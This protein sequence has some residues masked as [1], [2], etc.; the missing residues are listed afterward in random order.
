MNI[1]CNIVNLCPLLALALSLHW[2]HSWAFKFRDANVILRTCSNDGHG[3]TT[4]EQVTNYEPYV[5]LISGGI[6]Q[7]ILDK[8]DDIVTKSNVSTSCKESLQFVNKSL[9]EGDEASFRLIDASAKMPH[10]SIEGTVTNLGD[11]DECINIQEPQ[12]IGKYCMVDVF[13][14]R[15]AIDRP[16][17]FQF[18][19]YHFFNQTARF[20]GLCFPDTC[21]TSDVR[22]IVSRVLSPLTVRV[23][24]DITC[25]TLESTSYLSKLLSMT[26]GQIIS[27]LALMAVGAFV[28]LGTINDFLAIVPHDSSYL[29]SFLFSFSLRG[30]FQELVAPYSDVNRIPFVDWFKFWIIMTGVTAHI[31]TCLETPLGFFILEKHSVFQIVFR[32]VFTQFTFNDGGLGWI[33]FLSAFSCYSTLASAIKSKTFRFPMAVF[34]RW[35]KF[36][37]VIAAITALD[38]TWPLL[39]SGPFYTRVG[40]YISNKCSSNWWANVAFVSIFLPALD[41]CAPHTY[42]ASIDFLL[43][44]AGIFTIHLLIHYTKLGYSICLSAV[45]AGYWLMIHFGSLYSVPPSVMTPNIHP[46]KVI[47]FLDIIQMSPFGFMTNYFLGLLIAHLTSTGLLIFKLK[48]ALDHAIWVSAVFISL[49]IAEMLPAIYN[50]FNL[51]PESFIPYYLVVNRAAFTLSIT[52]LVIYSASVVKGPSK[53]DNKSKSNG[54]SKEPSKLDVNNNEQVNE[55]TK[56]LK[57]PKLFSI[58]THGFMRLK[59]L[60]RGIGSFFFSRLG[61]IITRLSFAIFLSNYFYIRLD[62]F[63]SRYTFENTV[64]ALVS[65]AQMTI[66]VLQNLTNEPLCLLFTSIFFSTSTG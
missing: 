66:W 15:P 41:I 6:S 23:T 61:A 55:G 34:D 12:L 22:T 57:K 32:S 2:S 19:K 5:R 65:I 17:L 60:S 36:A 28:F 35:I 37:P 30:N 9:H 46:Q 27:V 52:I 43:F 16:G 13:V 45:A 25:D 14:E 42:Y 7:L 53:S 26:K 11:Y 38:F 3:C 29:S 20:F 18:G 47:N 40:Q 24:G 1:F 64:F 58:E 33:T 54:E 31:I 59:Q 48:S 62:F 49:W 44:V 10:G 56:L 63:T 51:L 8:L 4:R 39:A 50:S 21:S